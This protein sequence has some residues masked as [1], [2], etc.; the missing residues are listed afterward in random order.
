MEELEEGRDSGR[1]TLGMRLKSVYCN[2][3]LQHMNN[4]GETDSG[5]CALSPWGEAERESNANQM[6]VI[7][8]DASPEK[9]SDNMAMEQ[10]LGTGTEHDRKWQK[11]LPAYRRCMLQV[12]NV[13]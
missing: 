2:D 12:Q 1:N 8:F 7:L 5:L 10:S 11:C 3:Y 4:Y 6:F 13:L 9:C